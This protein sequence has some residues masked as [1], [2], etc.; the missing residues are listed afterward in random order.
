MALSLQRAEYY[1]TTMVDRPGEA[2]QLLARLAG[3]GV[4]LHVFTAVPLDNLHTELVLFPDNLENF[5]AVADEAGVVLRGPEHAFLIQGDDH[6]G[7]LADIHAQLLDAKIN[8]YASSGVADGSGKFGYVLHVRPR[9]FE[10]AAAA[11]G[12]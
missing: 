1:R 11:L 5:E 4:N 9:D 6:L 3:A 8:V 10:A 12:V 7:A 2:Y